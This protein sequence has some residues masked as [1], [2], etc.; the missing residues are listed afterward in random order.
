MKTFRLIAITVAALAALWRGIEWMNEGAEAAPIP[1]PK[2]P[3][4]PLRI[5]KPDTCCVYS[6]SVFHDT[7][8]I[9]YCSGKIDTIIAGEF[10]TVDLPCTPMF[11]PYPQSVV[12]FGEDTCIRY[13]LDGHTDT[14]C[15]HRQYKR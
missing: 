8:L 15:T 12:W 13:Y 1:A 14:I 7:V 4:Q 2:F 11:H 9:Q 5:D 10:K 6:F 3:R